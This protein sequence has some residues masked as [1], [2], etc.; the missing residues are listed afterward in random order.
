MSSDLELQQLEDKL[1]PQ[2]WELLL[3]AANAALLRGWDL[4]LVGGAVRDLLLAGAK[5]LVLTD[6]DL[7]VD[8]CKKAATEGAG[9]ELAK[10]IQLLYPGC[11]LNVYGSFQTAALSWDGDSIFAGLGMDI[12]T[13]RTE[14]YPYSAANPIVRSSSIDLDLYRRDFTINA[15]ALRLTPNSMAPVLLDLYDGLTDLAAKQVRV[16]HSD[17]FIDDPT[18]IYRGARFAL[19]LGFSIEPQSTTYIRD[20]IN[21]GIYQQTAAENSK[22]PA[23]QSRLKTELKYLLEVPY[24]EPTLELLAELGGLQCIHYSLKLDSELLRQLRLLE[25]CLRRFDRTQSIVHWQLRLEAIIAALAPVYR[26]Q[27]AKNLQLPVETIDRLKK[28]DRIEAEIKEQLPKVDRISQITKVLRQFDRQTLLLIAARC[29]P[30]PNTNSIKIRRQI[31]KYLTDWINV[32]SI[33]TGNDLQRLGY[34]LG[35]QYRQILDKLLTATLDGQ[36]IDK[37]SAE[38]FLLIQ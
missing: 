12:A 4:Y 37:A 1:T 10:A 32:R 3:E 21:S 8:G 35:P 38:A 25:R 23:L 27:V 14:F 2:L 11:R 7:V 26:D 36:I 9:V 28:L 6:I 15:M 31:W 17:S 34:K 29:E 22:T 5:D 13:A 19:R 30:I 20:A 18:R 24:W 16:L 33:L